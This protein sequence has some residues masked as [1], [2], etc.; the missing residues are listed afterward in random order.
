MFYVHDHKLFR[1]DE[2]IFVFVCYT[3]GDITQ[4]AACLNVRHEVNRVYMNCLYLGEDISR[5]CCHGKKTSV[6]SF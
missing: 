4:R 2:R 6:G 3:T 5:V 1:Y